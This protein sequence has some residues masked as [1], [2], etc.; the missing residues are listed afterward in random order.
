MRAYVATGQV[1]RGYAGQAGLGGPLA[2]P[3]GLSLTCHDSLYVQ[4]PAWHRN[5]GAGGRALRGGGGRPGAF[6]DA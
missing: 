3:T 2:S 4:S 5:Q 1:A 6:E